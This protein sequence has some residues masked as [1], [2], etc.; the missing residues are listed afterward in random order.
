MITIRDNDKKP[1]PANP[2]PVLPERYCDC[3]QRDHPL[4][5]A[6]QQSNNVKKKRR[7]HTHEEE[8]EQRKGEQR[9]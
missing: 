3:Q 4:E 9:R 1:C 6:Q 2:N 5:A 8:Y 7:K